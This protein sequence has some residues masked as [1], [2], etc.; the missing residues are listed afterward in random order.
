MVDII[1]DGFKVGCILVGDTDELLVGGLVDAMADVGRDVVFKDTNI[2]GS[3][4]GTV[5]EFRPEGLNV[6]GTCEG[7]EGASSVGA[8]VGI[9]VGEL[10]GACVGPRVGLLLGISVGIRV[11]RLGRNVGSN[12]GY[13][14]GDALGT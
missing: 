13:P 9:K 14:E 4:V 5:V 12:I 2:E 3:I 11:G 6:N 1:D 8:S 10:E 7:S